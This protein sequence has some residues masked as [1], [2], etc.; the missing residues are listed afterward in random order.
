MY[1][2]MLAH[3]Q[4]V[5]C[6]DCTSEDDKR[7]RTALLYNIGWV[8][9]RQGRHAPAYR[10]VSEAYNINQKISGE[11][12]ATTSNS[13]SLLALVLQYQG[14]YE[15]AEEMNRR[16]VDGREKVLGVEHPD[17]LVSIGGLASVLLAQGKYEAAEEMHRQVLEG[18]EKVLGV[19]HPETLFSV[20]C[21]DYLFHYY[22]TT[23]QRCIRSLSQSFSRVLEGVGP[24]PSY[25]TKVLPAL[26]VHGR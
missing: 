15:A 2:S 19:E 23:V 10:E 17:I 26:R 9:W 13:L 8:N 22:A 20:Y 3:A 25:H 18:R 11:V 16:A 5:L 4:A 1:E 14:N 6:Y 7:H 12:A 24:G 21:L